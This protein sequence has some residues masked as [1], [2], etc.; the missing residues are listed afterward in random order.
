[1]LYR[2]EGIPED[3]E[4]ILCKVTKLFPNSVFVDILEYPGKQGMIHISEVSPGR[5]RNLRDFVS[6]DRQIVCKVLR[7]DRERGHIDLSLRRVNT[8]Q[9]SEKLEEIKQELKAEALISNLAKKLQQP[10]EKFYRELVAKV[11]KEYSHLYLCFR[12]LVAGT[13]NL[14]KMGVEKNLAKEIT[15][16][17]LDKFK[18]EKVF[19][20]GDIVLQSYLPDGVEKIKN[21]L[22]AIEKISTHIKT[23][24]LGAGRYKIRVEAGDYKEA[25]KILAKVQ[26][27]VTKFEDKLSTGSLIREKKE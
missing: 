7:I 18:P 3:E 19:L 27:V 15:T 8:T 1:M 14:E 25:E 11:F 4:I 2:R 17:V 10:A 23:T 16:A 24:Y 22:L 5:I 26:E 9:R 12:G 20:E 21:T 13:A 6:Q